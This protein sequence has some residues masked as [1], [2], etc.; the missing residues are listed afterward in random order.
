[1]GKEMDWWDS[2]GYAGR[3]YALVKGREVA[4]IAMLMVM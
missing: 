1:M 3:V 4:N 2:H